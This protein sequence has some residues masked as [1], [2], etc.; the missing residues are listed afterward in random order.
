MSFIEL[1]KK[2]H[3][4]RDY[5]DIPVERENILQVL[6][7]ARFA[8]SAVNYQPWH[9][10]VV[11]ENALKTKIANTYSRDWLKKAP[12]LIIV[13]GD[14]SK[15]WKRDDNK[16]HCDIDI[17]IAVDHMTLAAAEIGLGTCWV[18]KF[19]AKECHEILELPENIEVVAI[20]PI[21]HPSSDKLP[22]KKRMNLNDMVSFEKYNG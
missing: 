17:A 3:S 15:S 14:H 6:E 11:S 8:P 10:V 4:V 18:C 22:E 9:F 13:C 2:R 7:A 20:L 12:V 16:D 1:A 5:K 19:N 21:G